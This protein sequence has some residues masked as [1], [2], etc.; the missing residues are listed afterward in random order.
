MPREFA[1]FA[2]GTAVGSSPPAVDRSAHYSLFQ[3]FIRKSYTRARLYGQPIRYEK[4]TWVSSVDAHVAVTLVDCT[5]PAY[6]GKHL[7]CNS[8]S[9]EDN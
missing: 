3:N 8:T 9:I 5:F 6:F 4:I 2:Q 1:G 7:F